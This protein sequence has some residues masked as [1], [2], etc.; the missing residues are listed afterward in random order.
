MMALVF[1]NNSATGVILAMFYAIF[2]SLALPLETIMLPI[3]AADLFGERSYNKTLGIVVSVNTAGY[4]LG[5]P[6]MG[7][8]FDLT[9]SYRSG[10][11]I[12]ICLMLAT[13]A[14]IQIVITAANREKRRIIAEY[15]KSIQ[16]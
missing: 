4:A 16:N 15:N 10:F 6:M 9:G 7:V 12:A 8:C 2:V 11:I 1:V 5:A 13:I 14:L 3:Y